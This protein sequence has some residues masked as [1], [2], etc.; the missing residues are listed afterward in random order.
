MRVLHLGNLCN[1]SYKLAKF[2]RRLGVDARLRIYSSQIGTNDDPAW[3]DPE[4]KKAR[5]DHAR[6][7]IAR[8]FEWIVRLCLLQ[9]SSP[10]QL[11]AA[12]VSGVDL[13]QTVTQ[14]IRD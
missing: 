13:S 3:E 8:R 14:A 7:K 2:Q 9:P 5:V 11:G 4:L 10:L 6:R 12:S 1:N